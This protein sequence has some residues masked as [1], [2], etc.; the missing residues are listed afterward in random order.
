MHL[1]YGSDR[2]ALLSG[3][4][5]DVNL[6]VATGFVCHVIGDVSDPVA[7]LVFA[8]NVVCCLAFEDD[9]GL[10]L[11]RDAIGKDGTD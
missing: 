4:N 2:T 3:R 9:P 10:R 6:R 8:G 5:T 7:S 1:K 11:L